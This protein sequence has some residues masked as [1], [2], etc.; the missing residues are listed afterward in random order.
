MNF[1]V[2]DEDGNISQIF[3]PFKIK[4]LLFYFQLDDEYADHRG[5]LQ[6]QAVRER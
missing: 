3:S 4:I 2:E 6:G 1:Q 5:H